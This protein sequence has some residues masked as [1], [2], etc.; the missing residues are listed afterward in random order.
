MIKLLFFL[1]AAMLVSL[2]VEAQVPGAAAPP[3]DRDSSN[4]RTQGVAYGSRVMN[5]GFC[6]RNG[7]DYYVKS[8][9]ADCRNG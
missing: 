9:R 4:Q 5:P 8:G 7:S 6:A 3:A 2:T 1:G